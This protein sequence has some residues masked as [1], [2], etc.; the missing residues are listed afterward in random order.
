[1][2]AATARPARQRAGYSELNLAGPY[3]LTSPARKTSATISLPGDVHTALLKAKEIPDP[4]FGAN[5]QEVMWVSHTPWTMERAFARKLRCDNMTP[6]G[7][8]VL[9]DV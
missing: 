2:V 6:R 5:E 9:P 4:Y 1:M 3:R 7:R 8:P